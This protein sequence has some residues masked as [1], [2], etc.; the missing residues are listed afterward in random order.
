MKHLAQG[1]LHHDALAGQSGEEQIPLPEKPVLPRDERGAAL[2]EVLVA[3][4][5]ITTSGLATIGALDAALRD[6]I[7]LEAI[8]AQ[9]QHAN[10]LLQDYSLLSRG[11]LDQRIGEQHVG[12]LFVRVTRPQRALYRVAVGEL[13]HPD[14]EL[15]ATV[16]LRTADPQ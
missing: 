6:A 10:A 13:T 7:A 4:V 5:L 14:R 11:D 3:L 1:G 8:E 15:L 9:Q 12:P 2:L 16:L